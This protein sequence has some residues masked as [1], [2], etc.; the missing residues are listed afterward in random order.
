MTPAAQP[1]LDEAAALEAIKAA[2]PDFGRV[3]A[4]HPRTFVALE[5]PF[6]QK[7]R[8]VRLDVLTP[9]RPLWAHYALT[10]DGA[11][12]VTA[13][14]AAFDKAVAADPGRIDS[15]DAALALVAAR[16]AA[17]RPAGTRAQLVRGPADLPWMP[18]LEGADAEKKAAIEA[19]ITQTPPVVSE[20]EAGF[21]IA[22]WVLDGRALVWTEVHVDPDGAAR[23]QA[24]E[25]IEGLPFTY[26]L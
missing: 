25:R 5:T 6:L 17:V 16:V 3:A 14:P 13:D 12:R 19:R 26:A 23:S 9:E 4:R 10:A 21:T 2:D 24:G 18:K 11:V 1:S 20:A 15:A 8:V 22:A 7:T